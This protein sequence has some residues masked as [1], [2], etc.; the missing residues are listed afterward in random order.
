MR[1]RVGQRQRQIA[2]RIDR[3][4]APRELFLRSDGRVKYVRISRRQQVTAAALTTGVIGWTLLATAGAV[5]AIVMILQQGVELRDAGAQLRDVRAAYADLHRQVAVAGAHFKQMTRSL[6]IR[7]QELLA[8]T[9]AESAGLQLIAAAAAPYGAEAL[10]ETGSDLR[11]I[12]EGNE[13]L[14]GAIAEMRHRLD[15]LGAAEGRARAARDRYARLWQDAELELDRQQDRA[16]H[17]DAEMAALRAQIDALELSST[18]VAADRRALQDRV[19]EL[20]AALA[21]AADENVRL[22]ESVGGLQRTMAVIADDRN[23]LRAARDALNSQVEFLERRMSSLQSTQQTVVHQLTER[24]RLTVA[25]VE[26]TV[27]MAGLDVDALLAAASGKVQG[28]GG[29]FVP[30]ARAWRSVEERQVLAGIRKLNGE[31]DRWERLQVV[32]RHMPLA[33]PLDSYV[34]MSGFGERMDPFNGKRAFHAGVDLRNEVGTPVL[35]TAPGTVVYAAWMREYGRV[36]EIDHGLGIRTRYAHLKSI[37]VKVGD[38]VEFRQ[39]IGKVGSSGRSTGPHLHYEVQVN[40]KP[41][42]PMNF[43]EAGKYVFKG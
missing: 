40:G 20:T 21:A 16:T 7:Q 4:F 30:V 39:E 2:D 14:A 41:H 37:G 22:N 24:T 31:V 5:A 18:A 9:G 3:L 23:A 13:T 11:M 8:L 35:A 33:A 15:A 1:G 19:A 36:V 43:M 12:S 42:D 32:L 10:S 34:L 28:G 6:W 17:L 38:K 29:P 27:L 26:K 25:E